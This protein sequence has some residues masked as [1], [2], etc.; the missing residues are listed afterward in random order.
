MIGADMD[1]GYGD[2][3]RPGD[4]GTAQILER[5]G[6]PPAA[7][8]VPPVR[9]HAPGSGVV[10]SVTRYFTWETGTR[11]NMERGRLARGIPSNREKRELEEYWFFREGSFTAK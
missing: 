3:R 10:S 2:D 7:E 6:T 1:A 4:S 11:P 5:L 8:H 9:Q